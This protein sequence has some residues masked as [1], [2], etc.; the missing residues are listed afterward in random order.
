MTIPS[1]LSLIL[2]ISV[3]SITSPSADFGRLRK[4]SDFFGRLRTSLGI[5]GNDRVVCKNPRTPRIKISRL[6]L[7]KSWQVYNFSHQSEK[8]LNNMSDKIEKL[9]N[10]L[11]TFNNSS[12]VMMTSFM[13]KVGSGTIR[14]L[15]FAIFNFTNV[16]NFT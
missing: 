15:G 3:F 11:M 7:R 9:V 10:A 4:T 1:S 13:V 6:Y 16:S 12:N 5:F 8:F 2:W 14:H